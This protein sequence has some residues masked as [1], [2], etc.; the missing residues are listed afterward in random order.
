[1]KNITRLFGAIIIVSALFFNGIY[2]KASAQEPWSGLDKPQT[3]LPKGNA[4]F[5]ISTRV[6]FKD[7]KTRLSPYFDFIIF[8]VLF[9]LVF[10]CQ[11]KQTG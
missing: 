9:N 8:I 7:I 2:H 4:P 3:I 10:I 5:Q 6:P 1:M 11:K